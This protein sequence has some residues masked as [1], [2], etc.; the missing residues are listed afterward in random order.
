[1]WRVCHARAARRGGVRVLGLWLGLGEWRLALHLETWCRRRFCLFN[2]CAN[3]SPIRHFWALFACGLWLVVC[4]S[5]W[6]TY[7]NE[8]IRNQMEQNELLYIWQQSVSV[9]LFYVPSVSVC[10]CISSWPQM[11]SPDANG[12]LSQFGGTLCHIPVSGYADLPDCQAKPDAAAAAAYSY[13]S[14]HSGL[15]G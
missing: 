14:W 8:T 7:E 13:C 1:M 15:A 6:A 10:L 5:A 12:S 9:N 3:F 11:R 4:V 2:V